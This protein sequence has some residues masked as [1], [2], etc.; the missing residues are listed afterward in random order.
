MLILISLN[1]IL[2]KLELINILFLMMIDYVYIINMR[3]KGLI[4]FHHMS[5]SSL[6]RL[7][8]KSPKLVQPDPPKGW[9]SSIFEH[10]KKFNQIDLDRQFIFFKNSYFII[11]SNHLFLLNNFRTLKVVFATNKIG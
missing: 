7:F 8:T 2:V 9:F 3:I 6:D 1:N 11:C 5:T 4:N 10:S